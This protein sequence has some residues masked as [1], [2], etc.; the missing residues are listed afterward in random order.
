MAVG[1]DSRHLVHVESHI[2]HSLCTTLTAQF[3]KAE[4]Q[5][6]KH[7]EAVVLSDLEDGS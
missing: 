3:R 7:M 2:D 1:T 6:V 5:K 4:A